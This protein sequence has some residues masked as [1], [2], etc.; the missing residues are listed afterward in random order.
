[1]HGT[2]FII[3]RPEGEEHIS[4]TTY[5][6]DNLVKSESEFKLSV[7]ETFRT[8]SMKY[9]LVDVVKPDA[10]KGERGGIYLE[11]LGE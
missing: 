10:P 6:S 3:K 9:R 5:R 4:V 8:R 1:M 7:G 11:V 2:R